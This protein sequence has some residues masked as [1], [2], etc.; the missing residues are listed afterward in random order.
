MMGGWFV[1]DTIKEA[2]IM[3]R[4]LEEHIEQNPFDHIVPMMGGSTEA[5]NRF[6]EEPVFVFLKIWVAIGGRITVTSSSGRVAL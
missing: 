2:R 6:F 3:C 5:I 4:G 1:K